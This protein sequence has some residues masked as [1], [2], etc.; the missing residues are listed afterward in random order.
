V[1]AY[2]E[3][4]NPHNAA[5]LSVR[6]EFVWVTV[7]LWGR[8]TDLISFINKASAGTKQQQASSWGRSGTSSVFFLTNEANK[9][10]KSGLCVR[11]H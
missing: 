7:D 9:E 4:F 8:Q 2:R 10:S 5:G 1:S 6:H 11:G 3:T